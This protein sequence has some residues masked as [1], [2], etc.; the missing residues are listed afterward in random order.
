MKG[1]DYFYMTDGMKYYTQ[2]ESKNRWGWASDGREVTGLMFP[3]NLKSFSKKRKHRRCT[4]TDSNTVV[5][6]LAGTPER[7]NQSAPMQGRTFSDQ[8]SLGCIGSVNTSGNSRCWQEHL[9]VTTNDSRLRLYEMDGFCA[10]QKAI[11]RSFE[12]WLQLCYD[13]DKWWRGDYI[14]IFLKQSTLDAVIR[15]C[16]NNAFGHLIIKTYRNVIIIPLGSS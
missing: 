11:V 1:Q 14:K 8:S 4:S 13:C 12:S 16:N 2:L 7:L 15:Q 6:Q 5:T 10:I 9:L 3:V